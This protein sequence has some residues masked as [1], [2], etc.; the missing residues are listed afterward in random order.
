MTNSIWPHH[1]AI[2]LTIC[3]LFIQASKNEN[4]EQVAYNNNNLQMP[5][6][7]LSTTMDDDKNEKWAQHE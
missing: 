6:C 2:W 3:I 7:K 1:P 5:E 4:V